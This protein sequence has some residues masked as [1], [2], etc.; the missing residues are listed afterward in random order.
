M[1][2]EKT[3][4]GRGSICPRK[5]CFRC[6][7]WGRFNRVGR[8]NNSPR[9]MPAARSGP[10][11]AGRI[12]WRRISPARTWPPA[13]GSFIRIPKMPPLSRA[14]SGKRFRPCPTSRKSATFPMPPRRKNLL[15]AI[16]PFVDALAMTNSVAATVQEPA[17]QN[18][19]FDGQ[20]R[21]ICGEAT[22]EASLSQAALF[23]RL[24]S[25]RRTKNPH[26]RRGRRL[27]RRAC[28]RVSPSRCRVRAHRHRRDARSHRR[29]ANSR[30][31]GCGT[32]KGP[33]NTHMTRKIRKDSGSSGESGGTQMILRM[34]FLCDDQRRISPPQRAL[35]G[36]ERARTRCSLPPSS[37]PPDYPEGSDYHSCRGI[38][39]AERAVANQRTA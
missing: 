19:L 16:A 21:G 9:I 36:G 23:T 8:W 3:S 37:L 38:L 5:N 25:E 28:P 11:R 32:G 26:H 14:S 35:W 34:N 18:L 20:K 1:T 10:S 39:R 4:N 7:W 17:T 30:R 27:D 29:L 12:V 31:V 15:T 33:R 13:M 6:R 24:I 2:G 22:R